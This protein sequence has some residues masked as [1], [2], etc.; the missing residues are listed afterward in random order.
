MQLAHLLM[1]LVASCSVLFFFAVHGESHL[2]LLSL[3]FQN[4]LPPIVF[5]LK[6]NL[7]RNPASLQQSALSLKLF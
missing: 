1:F 2:R 3:T 6:R 5:F 4:V 7:L